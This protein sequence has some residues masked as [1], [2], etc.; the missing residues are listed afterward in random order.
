MGSSMVVCKA[1]YQG[2]PRIVH[3]ILEQVEQAC[4]PLSLKHLSDGVYKIFTQA[5]HRSRTSLVL[6]DITTA[7]SHSSYVRT[8]I[9]AFNALPLCLAGYY[10]NIRFESQTIVFLYPACLRESYRVRLM[11]G[12]DEFAWSHLLVGVL[13]SSCRCAQIDVNG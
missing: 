10:Y 12:K 6:E 9:L 13:K 8:S 3:L 5:Q 2:C 7:F 11:T 1:S 4:A